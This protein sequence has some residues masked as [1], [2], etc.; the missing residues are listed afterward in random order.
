M[1]TCL[2]FLC[3]PVILILKE[4]AIAITGKPR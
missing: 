4:I 3:F 2:S 1:T